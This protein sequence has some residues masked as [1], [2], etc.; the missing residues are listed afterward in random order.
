MKEKKKY[1]KPQAEVVDFAK[2]DIIVTSLQNGG[3][4]PGF[5]VGEDWGN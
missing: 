4:D 2:E 5:G 3:S 1:E